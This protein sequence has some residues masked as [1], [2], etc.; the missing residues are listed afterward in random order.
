MKKTMILS[1]CLTMF[2]VTGCGKVAQLDNGEDIVATIEGKT[3]TANNLYDEIKNRF[4]RNVLIDMIDKTILEK[5]Y[6]TTD[7]M[8]KYVNDT[9]EFYKQQLGENFLPYIKREAGVNSEKEFNELLLLE[10]KRN[11]AI[12]DYV[13]SI[14]TDK[15]IEDYYENETVGDIKASHILIKPDVKDDMTDEEKEEKEK[16]AL[17]LAKEIITKLDNGEKFE[18]LAKEHSADGSASSGGDLGWFNKGKMVEPFEEAAFALEKGKYSKEPVKSQF[19]YHIILKTD[20]KEKPSLEKAKS[21]ILDKLT[22]EKLSEED[23]KLPFIALMEL[24]KEYK[25]DIQDSELKKQYESYI[26]SLI[27]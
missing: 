11:E 19:G 26:N 13:K 6:E 20:E 9:I 5:E 16:E 10:Y 18:D 4:A 1:L 15:E 25:L 14:I 17:E 12:K 27:K 21:D 23:T 2:L 22:E 3:I 24:R 8:T 7:E